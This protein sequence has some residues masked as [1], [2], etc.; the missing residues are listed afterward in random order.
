MIQGCY[1]LGISFFEKKKKKRLIENH[2]QARLRYFN[3]N[4]LFYCLRLCRCHGVH[5]QYVRLR[6]VSSNRKISAEQNERFAGKS[7]RLGY[8]NVCFCCSV[9]RDLLRSRL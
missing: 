5:R 3:R 7:R 8:S 4:H 9:L 6:C 1:N 2:G